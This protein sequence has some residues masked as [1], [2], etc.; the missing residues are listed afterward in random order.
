MKAIV[1]DGYGPPENL[2]LREIDKPALEDDGVRVRVRAASINPVDWHLI[3][4]EPF[5]IKVMNA[6][7][8]PKG[9]V[10]GIDVAGEVEE[11]GA[12]VTQFRPGDAV[13]GRHAG[14]LAEYVCAGE[15][16]L[17]PKPA[18][19]TWQQAAAIP[20]AG[21]TALQAVRDH[22]Q[23]QPGQR[24]LVIGAAGG[25][26]TFAVQIAKAFGAHVTG[27][28]STRNLELVRSIGA[29]DVV[30]YTAEDFN[31]NGR[32]YDVVLQVCGDPSLAD[33]RR[34]MAPDGTLV[35]VGGGTG[36]DEKGDGLLGPL[37]SM[38]RGRLLSWFTRQRFRI[39][40]TKGRSDDLVFLSELV[41]AGKVTPVIDRSYP[42]ADAAEA[43][44][45][46]E[47]GHARGKVIVTP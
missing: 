20:V 41:E 1:H 14:S 12:S 43:I 35:L 22:G 2:E 5:L 28:C 13:F 32:R 16:K 3:R 15:A 4:G 42:L 9:E 27:V 45:Y 40:L 17:V 6:F 26:G 21:S 36:R 34:A 7:R 23:V 33:L 11:V 39:F 24:V 31:G 19:L 10:P 18:A 47:G 37:A 30:D 44:R 8:A 25:V 38:I 29:D 46:L